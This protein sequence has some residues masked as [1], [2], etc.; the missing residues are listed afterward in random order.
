MNKGTTVLAKINRTLLA[1]SIY[2]NV[3]IFLSVI[4]LTLFR[5]GFTIT[6]PV[7]FTSVVLTLLSVYTYIVSKKLN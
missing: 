2:P 3:I 4:A 6:L 1:L 7:Y 5:E